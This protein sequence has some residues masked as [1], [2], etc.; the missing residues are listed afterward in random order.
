VFMRTVLGTTV[1]ECLVAFIEVSFS[2]G[3]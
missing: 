1:M 2:P 3:R